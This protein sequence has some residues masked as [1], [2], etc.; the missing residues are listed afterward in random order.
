MRNTAH[1]QVAQSGPSP[2]YFFRLSER[3]Y[4]CEQGVSTGLMIR[5][6]FV[7]R[8]PRDRSGTLGRG[9]GCSRGRCGGGGWRGRGLG[10]SDFLLGG[11][12]SLPPAWLAAW[13]GWPQVPPQP[14]Q[15][16]RK[17]AQEPS[18]PICVPRRVGQN[19]F[20]LFGGREQGRVGEILAPVCPWRSAP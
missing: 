4:A 11:S 17:E 7:L 16:T 19:F 18:P 1:C 9:T 6:Q 5:V 2:E 12:A 20:D 14:G 10:S 15:L 3:K 8:F 13:V